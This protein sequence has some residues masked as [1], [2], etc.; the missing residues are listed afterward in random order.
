[1]VLIKSFHN[2]HQLLLFWFTQMRFLGCIWAWHLYFCPVNNK[3]DIDVTCWTFHFL[4]PLGDFVWLLFGLGIILK[5][6]MGVKETLCCIKGLSLPESW[7]EPRDGFS[8]C[9]VTVQRLMKG[10]VSKATRSY[11]L[12]QKPNVGTNTGSVNNNHLQMAH[13]CRWTYCSAHWDVKV[14]NLSI[15]Y[16]QTPANDS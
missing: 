10:C 16:F 8:C 3:H 7:Y 11:S 13:T 2:C 1:M 5:A 15:I 12:M 14:C 4:I 9:S 6:I